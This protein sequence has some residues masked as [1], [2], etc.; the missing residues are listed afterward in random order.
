MG[1]SQ[2]TSHGQNEP[3]TAYRRSNMHREGGSD[4]VTP[5]RPPSFDEEWMTEW[6]E[7]V[8]DHELPSLPPAVAFGESV[9]IARWAGKHFGA[10]V[11]VQWMWSDDHDDDYMATEI[12][13][14]RRVGDSSEVSSGG[15]GGGWFDPP[16][17]L[18]EVPADYVSL[19]H[20]HS[21]GDDGWT[22]CA[23]YGL[24]GASA[25]MIDVVTSEGTESHPVESPL[26]VFIVA[27]GGSTEA[28]ARVRSRDG[29]VLMDARFSP[30]TSW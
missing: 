21:S 12:E 22:C 8:L 29:R 16:F 1:G 20:F 27:A 17:E 10:V 26:G 9:P 14:F 2:S 4:Q 23:A 13:V 7:W 30:N 19:H 15:G 11:H 6:S 28:R 25:H 24:V 3:R 18:P 5:S